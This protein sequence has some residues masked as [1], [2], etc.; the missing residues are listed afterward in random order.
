M[1]LTGEAM[2]DENLVALA[3]LG[4]AELVPRPVT[5]TE[6]A[7][8]IVRLL[9]AE[10]TPLPLTA[11]PEAHQARLAEQMAQMGLVDRATMAAVVEDFLAA[12]DA[13]GLAFPDGLEG[14]LSL[15]DG[16][17][18]ED[19]ASRL[20]RRAAMT[21]KADPWDRIAALPAEE[22]LPLLAD[23]APET[24]A[25]A[26]SRLPVARAAELLSL[27]PG[28]RARRVALAMAR[29]GG[30]APDMLRRIGLAL[31][32]QL[33]AR[34]PKAFAT[35]PVQRMGAILNVAPGATRDDVLA[36]LEEEDRP[37]A[38]E[39]RKAIFTF[40]HIPHRV[41]PRDMPRV[42]R[43]VDQ[44]QV[45]TAFTAALADEVL[46]PVVEAIFSCLSPRI[47][48]QMRDEIETRGK[49]TAKDADAAYGAIVGAI[50]NMEA[51]GELTLIQEEEG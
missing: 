40:A 21:A 44:G 11:L 43:N 41:E 19:V 31:T 38:E 17:I 26:L 42:L 50:R 37:F 2:K 24:A 35:G 28:A 22:L 3:R 30:I 25:V 32:A 47:V 51:A 45:V 23:E 12:L 20:R 1:T 48:Q 8:I 49:V 4:P 18:S 33:D 9:M 36:G 39:V 15:V 46:A 7:A 5:P 29:T 16:H 14:A 10:G 6:K 34:P 27:M 13:A